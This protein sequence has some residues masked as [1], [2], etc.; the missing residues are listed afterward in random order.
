MSD[1]G[2]GRVTSILIEID[3]EQH[4]V[5]DETNL[6]AVLMALDGEYRVH[7][8]RDRPSAPYCLMGACFECLVEVDGQTDRQTCLLNT[9]AG[10]VIRRQRLP[11]EGFGYPRDALFGARAGGSDDD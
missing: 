6:A 11:R 4:E 8:V 5:R 9:R 10:M 7:P 3:G 2:G 1:S